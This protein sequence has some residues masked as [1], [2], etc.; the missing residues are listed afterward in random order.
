MVYLIA[1]GS[2]VGFSAYKWLLHEVRPALAGTYAFVNPVVAVL[3]G[4]TFA[5]EPL[6]P[7]LVVAMLTIVGAVAMITLRPYLSRR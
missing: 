7:R 4:W 2:I 5:G 1:F 6:T 3:L